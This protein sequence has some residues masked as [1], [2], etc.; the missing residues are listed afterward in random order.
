MIFTDPRFRIFHNAHSLRIKF[1]PWK[2]S[3]TYKVV[4]ILLLTPL[5]LAFLANSLLP[6]RALVMLKTGAIFSNSSVFPGWS[7]SNNEEQRWP[8]REKQAK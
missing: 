8:K 6:L 1:K 5:L 2:V 7:H 3:Y 4:L